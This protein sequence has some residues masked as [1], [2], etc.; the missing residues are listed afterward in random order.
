[1][2]IRRPDRRNGRSIDGLKACPQALVTP[3]QGVQCGLEGGNI[4]RT[5]QPNGT[6]NLL[7]G[8]GRGIEL[9]QEPQTFL[10]VA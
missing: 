4:Q 9:L 7:H 5:R 3:H 2:S 10:L 6:L 8:A 1:M